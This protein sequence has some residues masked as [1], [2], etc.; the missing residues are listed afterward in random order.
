MRIPAPRGARC[1]TRVRR[2][3]LACYNQTDGVG[4]PVGVH[5][6]DMFIKKLQLDKAILA[7]EGKEDDDA[8]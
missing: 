5:E 3:T 2:A 7:D 6:I 4:G 1:D 8:L